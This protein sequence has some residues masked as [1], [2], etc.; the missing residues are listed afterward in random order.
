MKKRTIINI[1]LFCLL[2]ITINA[3]NQTS[4]DL[5]NYKLSDNAIT[6]SNYSSEIDQTTISI[7]DDN[8]LNIIVLDEDLNKTNDSIF[9]DLP[10]TGYFIENSIITSKNINY[11]LAKKDGYMSLLSYN[12][13]SKSWELGNSLNRDGERLLSTFSYKNQFY[14]FNYE[15]KNGLIKVYT[16]ESKGLIPFST[17]NLSNFKLGNNDLSY[18]LKKKKKA[19]KAITNKSPN[20]LF[21]ARK[22]KK[23]YQF[24]EL[25]YF[26]IDDSISHNV[27]LIKFN[28]NSKKHSIS[29]FK[30]TISSCDS[31]Q[32]SKSTLTENY[33]ATISGCLKKATINFWDLKSEKI[34]K[35]ASFAEKEL[36]TI[37]NFDNLISPKKAQSIEILKSQVLLRKLVAKEAAIYMVEKEN[38]LELIVGR[39]IIKKKKNKINQNKNSGGGKGDGTGGGRQKKLDRIEKRKIKGSGIAKS[40]LNYETSKPQYFVCNYN[41]KSQKFDTEAIYKNTF[42]D[43]RS[44]KIK[45]DIRVLNKQIIFSINKNYWFGFIN[46]LSKHLELIKI[47]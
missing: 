46:P 1:L 35:S 25:V 40:Y 41:I 24:N 28:L 30:N 9:F 33:L 47:D 37:K 36:I 7:L 17:Y 8:K 21:A 12:R 44:F 27:G 2:S 10:S 32:F 13:D 11:L 38:N 23:V 34:I 6:Y 45:N 16:A 42:E 5:S 26:S 31:L 18:F 4:I 14:I 22:S 29:Y 39:L 15:R 3:Q 20:D 19:F 43:I